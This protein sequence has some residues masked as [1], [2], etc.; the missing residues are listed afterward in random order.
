[1]SSRITSLGRWTALAFV[2]AAPGVSL[3]QEYPEA[4]IQWGVTSGE[5]C[6]DIAKV[7]Y[8]STRHAHLVARYNRVSC[9]AGAPLAPA[10]LVLPAKV[11]EVARARLGSLAP[12]VRL[13]PPGAGWSTASAG[14]SLLDNSSVNTLED[15]NATIQ[16]VDTTRIQLSENTLV[17]IFGTASK[18]SVSTLRPADFSVDS[19]EI[20][21]AL[22][23]LRG[24]DAV[25]VDVAG[26]RVSAASK[27]T[28]ISA[29]GTRTN[30]AVF[31]GKSKVRSQGSAVN[32]DE[33]F[34]TRFEKGKAPETPRAL[35]KAPKWKR[36][37]P[38]LTL[39]EPSRG[40]LEAAWEPTDEAVSYRV[41]I[42]KDAEFFQLLA[43]EEVTKEITSFRAENLAEG[44]YFVRVRVL[45]ADEFL[46]I[47]ATAQT[48][49]IVGVSMTGQTGELVQPGKLTVHPYG[50]LALTNRPA[51]LAIAF[52]DGATLPAPETIVFGKLRPRAIDLSLGGSKERWELVYQELKT[53]IAASPSPTGTSFTVSI[54]P[55]GDA[56]NVAR[57]G[58]ALLTIED[59][60]LT[61]HALGAPVM[62]DGRARMQVAVAGSPGAA[63]L[64]DGWGR[65]LGTWEEPAV[66]AAAPKTAPTARSMRPFAP[67]VSPWSVD[68]AVPRLWAPT[69][70]NAI[71]ASVATMQPI[72]VETGEASEPS[73]QGL[74]EIAGN[75]ETVTLEAAF[76]TNDSTTA[77]SENEIAW[78]GARYRLIELDEGLLDVGPGLRLGFPTADGGPSFQADVGVAAAGRKG[79]WGWIADVVFDVDGEPVAYPYVPSLATGL[80]VQPMPWFRAFAAID[81]YATRKVVNEL[82]II[83]DAADPRFAGGLSLG[84]EAG[85]IVFG[86]LGVRATPFESPK[87]NITF[88]AALGLRTEP[89]APA[90]TEPAK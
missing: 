32:V 48:T 37:L 56:S 60:V 57:M 13:K 34:G 53:D 77:R 22:R 74:I 36:E 81:L 90:T 59:G 14:Q 44:T 65:T 73:V 6:E 80:V 24:E 26:G 79:M 11:T 29:K 41:E 86:A 62:E 70:Q 25:E 69:A 18:S 52:D 88:T 23:A 21:A 31:N 42:A 43:R 28:V 64:V 71:Y 40:V 58:G 39:G 1:M 30:V 54:E 38:T 17:I 12:E 2:L 75:I 16:F 76:R 67:I 5:T 3:A 82:G 63:M 4:V 50:S 9:T 61:K 51:D 8:G 33:G 89:E 78:V 19:G 49:T 68:A 35:P 20:K 72:G 7:V 47:A 66:D 84:A 83:T 87:Q 85:H 46:G 27:D 55:M 15:A 45:D 10:T